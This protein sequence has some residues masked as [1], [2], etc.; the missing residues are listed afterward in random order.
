M[1]NVPDQR[2]RQI[3]VTGANRM[4]GRESLRTGPKAA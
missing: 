1:Y 3:V 2:G 4:V